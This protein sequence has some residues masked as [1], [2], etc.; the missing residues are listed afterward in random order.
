LADCQGRPI[1]E[2]NLR[3][4]FGCSVVGIER[5]GYMT[6]LPPPQTVLYPRDRVLLMGATEQIAAA[7]KFLGAVTGTGGAESDF[8]EIRME[9]AEVPAWSRA[10]GRTLGELSPARSHGV[11][12]AGVRRGG[13]RILN[14]TADERLQSGDEV[15][16]LGTPVQIRD[17]HAW[18]RG[19]PEHAADG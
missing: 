10:T 17:F 19:R 6:P 2:L 7:K 3:T 1:A 12:I 4:R 18:L 9:V 13:T 5:Q 15:L 8:G 16:V 14:P 11:Q